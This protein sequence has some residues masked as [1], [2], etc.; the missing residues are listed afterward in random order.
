VNEVFNALK[1]GRVDGRMVLDIGLSSQ[2]REVAHREVT[3]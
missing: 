1:A 3:A 2:S